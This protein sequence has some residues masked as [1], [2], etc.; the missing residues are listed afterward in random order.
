MKIFSG[1]GNK[2]ILGTLTRLVWRDEVR[3]DRPEENMGGEQQSLRT[4]RSV[5]EEM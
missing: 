1:L 5:E 4:G 2:D 3:W